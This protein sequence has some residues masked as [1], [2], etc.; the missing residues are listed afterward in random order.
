[1]SRKWEGTMRRILFREVQIKWRV[2]E[3]AREISLEYMGQDIVLVGLLKGAF[4]FLHDL[5]VEL[6]R[7]K[8]DDKGV[9]RVYIDFLSV[10]SYGDEHEPGDLKLELDIRRPVAGKHVIIVEDVADTC[11]TLVWVV[12]HMRKKKPTSL[13]LCVLIDKPDKHK[14]ELT[15]DYVGFSDEDL[16]FLGGYGLDV[17]GADRCVP[18]IFEVPAE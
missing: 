11:N 2:Q 3:L 1:M 13:K 5:G 18:Y 17:N 8:T 9:E 4:M 7:N 10:G 15:L 16:P 14:H 6:E 12:D